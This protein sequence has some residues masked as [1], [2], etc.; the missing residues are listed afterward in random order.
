[1]RDWLAFAALFIL[2]IVLILGGLTGSMGRLLASLL[3]PSQIVE[4]TG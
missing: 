1:M 2:S 3:V 4:N